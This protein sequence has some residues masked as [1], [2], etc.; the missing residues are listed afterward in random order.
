[1]AVDSVNDVEVERLEICPKLAELDAT[2][3]QIYLEEIREIN[4]RRV[5]RDRFEQVERTKIY[6]DTDGVRRQADKAIRESY[7]RFLVTLADTTHSNQAI[8]FMKEVQSIISEVETDGMRIHFPDLPVNERDQLFENA[9]RS[10]TEMLISSQE[11]GLAAYLS[12]RVRHGTM[13]NQ[14]RSAFEI[15]SIL[16]QK[17]G[18]RYVADYTWSNNLGLNGQE[19]ALWLAQR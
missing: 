7:D 18:G 11:Y 13:G 4:R 15:N 19:N 14:L 16:T 2:N 9:V 17:D 12:T 10:L 8:E 1:M 5:V 3:R 6:V